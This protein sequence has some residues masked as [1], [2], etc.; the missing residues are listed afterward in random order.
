[1]PAFFA[2]RAGVPKRG[3][4]AEPSD[5]HDTARLGREGGGATPP[6]ITGGQADADTACRRPLLVILV[7]LR[8]EVSQAVRDRRHG[9]GR[10]DHDG[11]DDC[12]SEEHT[13]ELQSLMRISYAVFC[14][15]KKKQYTIF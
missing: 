2:G 7:V 8:G 6:S 12:R 10:Q 15:K 5:A 4:A 11:G 3:L 1:M 9:I 14:L 13:S